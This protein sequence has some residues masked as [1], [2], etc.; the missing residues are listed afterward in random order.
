[1]AAAA[2]AVTLRAQAYGNGARARRN[3]KAKKRVLFRSSFMCGN[4][5]FSVRPPC[6]KPAPPQAIAA[7]NHQPFAA[8]EIPG[9]NLKVLVSRERH[10]PLAHTLRSCYLTTGPIGLNSI[11]RHALWAND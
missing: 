9:Q 2:I 10:S 3:I 7:L 1:M 4:H 8:A 5:Q 11:R 6:Q